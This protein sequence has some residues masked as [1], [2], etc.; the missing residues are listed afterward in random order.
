LIFR[1]DHRVSTFRNAIIRSKTERNTYI[2][3]E[4]DACKDFGGLTFRIPF[5]KVSQLLSL[6]SFSLDYEAEEGTL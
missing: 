6:F 1:V 3:D 5:E 2:A 4:W